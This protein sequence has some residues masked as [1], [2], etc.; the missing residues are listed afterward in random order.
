MKPGKALALKGN[1]APDKYIL[2]VQYDDETIKEKQDGSKQLYLNDDDKS[3]VY[4]DFVEMVNYDGY[5]KT[6]NSNS[7]IMYGTNYNGDQSL[8]V[9]QA[10]SRTVDASGNE[11]T[12]GFRG[13]VIPDGDT[14]T[15]N[16]TTGVI[17]ATK[18][19]NG[20]ALEFRTDALERHYVDVITD[21]DRHAN[22]ATIEQTIKVNEPFV[23][24]QD[25]DSYITVNKDD[26]TLIYDKDNSEALAV[27][28]DGNHEDK[29]TH[30]TITYDAVNLV[31]VN[32][33]EIARP[34]SELDPGLDPVTKE[35]T[36]PQYNP[37]ILYDATEEYLYVPKAK[38]QQWVEPARKITIKEYGQAGLMYP[39]GRT[40]EVT[41]R[42][43]L[44]QCN[45]TVYDETKKTF[46]YGDS[47]HVPSAEAI[48][49]YVNQLDSFGIEK[50]TDADNTPEGHTWQRYNLAT[51]TVETVVGTL[52]AEDVLNKATI[53]LIP[54]HLVDDPGHPDESYN[55]VI[56]SYVKTEA[57]QEYWDWI[58]IG[59]TKVELQ[60]YVENINTVAGV[61]FQ[62]ESWDLDK[63]DKNITALELTNQLLAFNEI[64]QGT[65]A[66]HGLRPVCDGASLGGVRLVDE[67]KTNDAGEDI[68]TVRSDLYS[69]I[70][71]MDDDDV[72]NPT[73]GLR[74]FDIASNTAS[75]RNSLA[76][77]NDNRAT[78]NFTTTIGQSNSGVSNNSFLAGSRLVSGH[79][80]QTVFG[81]RN[82]EDLNLQFMVGNG[83]GGQESNSFAISHL[84][85]V[86]NNKG[87]YV[88]CT[89]WTNQA[90]NYGGKQITP[91]Q[92]DKTVDGLWHTTKLTEIADANGNI[93]TQ[94][95][96]LMPFTEVD[97][98]GETGV[99]FKFLV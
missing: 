86:Y 89:D 60:K 33:D 99:K 54:E 15:M 17:S 10:T 30:K 22:D 31:H 97:G 58:S 32:T 11:L 8:Y 39:D 28:I 84:G 80:N 42:G 14:I 53:Y 20:N 81:V 44:R 57:G 70:R 50:C 55:Q 38:N 95:N 63:D 59:S 16:A 2:D 36:L 75:G 4:K 29:V 92:D 88:Y 35:P 21:T 13:V 45:I 72:F 24:G 96:S 26:E 83:A 67:G 94:I 40:V 61:A 78:G 90:N 47:W 19:K 64:Q 3:L 56:A 1:T 71:P 48:I 79:D 27:N 6:T 5:L 25:N 51:Q 49:S 43:E 76:I 62:N 9:R 41:D 12:T 52:V 37:S 74:V 7:T 23:L 65:V 77:G 93:T 18:V 82:V 98:D 34:T 66:T 85:N 87:L 46:E 91:I 68:F 73:E 69:Y